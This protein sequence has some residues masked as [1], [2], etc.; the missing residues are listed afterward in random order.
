MTDYRGEECR[1]HP[2]ELECITNGAGAFNLF[3]RWSTSVQNID[4]KFWME[5]RDQYGTLFDISKGDPNVVGPGQI[6]VKYSDCIYLDDRA[7]LN[8]SINILE[9][10]T[11]LVKKDFEN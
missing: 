9:Y 2:E 3:W 8:E 11:I 4:D 1:D 6:P 7:G 5:V 10:A